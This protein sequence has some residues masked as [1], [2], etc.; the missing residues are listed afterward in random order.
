MERLLIISI[1]IGFFTTLLTIPSWIKRAKNAKLIGKDIHKFKESFVAES[2]GITVLLGFL[3]GVLSFVA[4]RTFYFKSNEY[5]IEIFSLL[6]VVT[7]AG[8]VGFADDILG[9]KIGLTKKVR[10]LLLS[11]ASI[12][13]VVINAGESTMMG[14][15]FGLIYP[16][17]LVP[18]GIIGATTTYN[19]L[20]GYNGLE[21]SQG[22]IILSALS[23]IAYRT[24][25]SWLSL[26]LI[27]LVACLLAL[28]LFNKYPAKV[29]P[30]NV[31]TYL[32]GSMIAISAILGNMEKIAIFFFIP[33][34]LETGLKLR[35]GLSKESFGKVKEDG[36]IENR[37]E[38]FYGLE[39]IAVATLIKIKGTAT[40]K[41]VVYVINLLQIIVICIGLFLFRANIF[42]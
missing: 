32:I 17:I 5:L 18:I 6:L 12:P 24:G 19:F 39:H 25:N 13:L 37:Y 16:L 1:I 41:E 40:E 11:F 31:L 26:I 36:T 8:I 27:I 22:I 29:F 42:I 21:V 10:I 15:D 23:F 28:Y 35:G 20:A 38:K 2:G 3:I 34:I 14:I 30:G 33:Y 4:I 7:L 9:W